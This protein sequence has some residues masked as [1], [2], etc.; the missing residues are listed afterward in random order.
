[1]RHIDGSNVGPLNCSTKKTVFCALASDPIERSDRTKKA[2]IG[3]FMRY[4]L[5]WSP[6][7]RPLCMVRRRPIRVRVDGGPSHQW[8][9]FMRPMC[10]HFLHRGEQRASLAFGLPAF[11]SSPTGHPG[12]RPRLLRRLGTR[13]NDQI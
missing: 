8:G 11:E 4:L 1:V 7:G 10:C 5:L 13:S 2:H 6:N 12:W 3:A 9:R